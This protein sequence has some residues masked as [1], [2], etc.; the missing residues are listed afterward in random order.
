MI[1]IKQYIK[2]NESKNLRDIDIDQMLDSHRFIIDP[3]GRRSRKTRNKKRK[4][5]NVALDDANVEKRYYQA[6]PTHDQAK[7]IFWE[8]LLSFTKPLNPWVNYTTLSVTFRHN[9][10]RIRVV[11]LNKPERI[12]GSTNDG[13][14][15]TEMPELGEI[16][17][18]DNHIYP[19]LIDTNGFAWID[20][21]PDYRYPWYQDFIERY[22]G[23][24]P[25]ES[26][27]G[28]PIQLESPIYPDWMYY[29][30]C[31]I[32]VLGEKAVNELRQQ[33]DTLSFQQEYEGKFITT[34]GRVY[35]AF[36]KENYSEDTFKPDRNTILSFDFNV[37]PMTC[38]MFQEAGTDSQGSFKYCAVKEFS[39]SNSNTWDTTNAI[40]DW[41][42]SRAFTGKLSVTG[43]R[44]GKR[45]QTGHVAGYSDLKI[46]E[47]RF[48]N[49]KGYAEHY[50]DIAYRLKDSINATN[51]M[52]CNS[53]GERL[54]FINKK[55]CPITVRD[56]ERQV[57][58]PDGQ[59]NKEGD[60][61]GHKSDAVRYFAY[62]FS[63]MA[64]KG[65]TRIM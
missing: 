19:T 24:L 56:L 55:E 49:Y 21:T 63:N 35:Y 4:M 47:E 54:L 57:F 27:P 1:D 30:W 17:I 60:T 59:L 34:G 31:S 42:T 41:L 50:R 25:P 3:S 22:M 62:G 8:D 43:D 20:G 32:D 16:E 29:H 44:T 51:G 18:W 6:A 13:I 26:R 65:I 11:G 37:N 28:S 61:I 14:H 53:L 7:E 40:D 23:S 48:K 46:I 38:V 36:T 52:F 9:G 58:L 12:E 10:T 2:R 5:Y 45:R 15:I 39:F 64:N 33:T